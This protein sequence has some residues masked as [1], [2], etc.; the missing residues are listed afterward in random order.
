VSCVLPTPALS[1]ALILFLKCS[2]PLL[3][4]SPDDFSKHL[5]ADTILFIGFRSALALIAHY[6]FGFLAGDLL[7]A[8]NGPTDE[9]TPVQG[10]T[11]D[12]ATES[13]ID[14]WGPRE[15]NTNISKRKLSFRGVKRNG[16]SAPREP[17]N[18]RKRFLPFDQVFLYGFVSYFLVSLSFSRV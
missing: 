4:Y 2:D 13:I 5:L 8:V 17:P 11:L 15:V 7:L 18:T 10:F 3:F 6:D 1:G 12:P 14:T 9:K 16:V